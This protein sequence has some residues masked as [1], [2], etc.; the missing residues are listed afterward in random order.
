MIE[1]ISLS[2]AFMNRPGRFRLLMK[3]AERAGWTCRSVHLLEPGCSVGDASAFMADQGHYVTAFDLSGTLISQARK[4][5][6][7][8]ERLKFLEAD[9]VS[10]PIGNGSVDGIYCEAAFSPMSP[11]ERILSEYHRVLRT[12]GMMLINDFFI[13]NESEEA[14][15]EEVIHIPCFAGVQTREC[16]EAL[17]ENSGFDIVEFHEEYGELIGITAWLCKVYKVSPNE[18]GGYLSMYFHEGTDGGEACSVRSSTA[19]EGDFFKRSELSYCQMI[20]QKKG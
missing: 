13:R 19:S 11:K 2:E 9:A 3:G 1:R 10:I 16:Y 14:A 6:H 8:Y 15:R 7:E 20:I 18:I 17:L 12:G 4:K 5:H